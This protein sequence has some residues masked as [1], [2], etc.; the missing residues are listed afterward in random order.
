MG[1]HHVDDDISAKSG[2]VVCTHDGIVR[3]D[4]VGAR[5]VFQQSLNSGPVF[6]RPFH[7]RHETG[8]RKAVTGAATADDV[9]ETKRAVLVKGAIT[10]MCIRP[11]VHLE[12]PILL[13]RTHVD[14][15]TR[16]PS[17]VVCPPP[18]IDDVNGLFTG[19][20]AVLDEREQDPILIVG[21]VEES[22]DVTVP[23]QSCPAQPYRSAMYLA[24]GRA[25]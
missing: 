10:Q 5:L 17:N 23:A 20:N 25:L 1:P 8:T 3:R 11:L 2:E 22:A 16:K 24:G 18:W 9:D 6:E 15:N 13:Y 4:K 21:A 19:L 14:A 7:V 12:L